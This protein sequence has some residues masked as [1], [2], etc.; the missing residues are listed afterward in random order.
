MAT[1]EARKGA[2]RT[3][4]R[5][6]IR[7]KG[8]PPVHRSFTR[9]TDARNWAQRIETEMRK[10]T[11]SAGSRRTLAEAI[12][13]F[14]VSQMKTPSARP[15]M[16]QMNRLQAREQQRHASALTQWQSLMVYWVDGASDAAASASSWRCRRAS[17]SLASVARRSR[18]GLIRCRRRCGPTE[19]CSR[20][21]RHPTS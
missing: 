3:T 16:Q 11:Y 19:T 5:V 21:N 17:A 1:I 7:L 14:R 9:L 15:F 4:Y 10:G 8:Q 20:L 6:S 2:K 12:D 18:A 13:A